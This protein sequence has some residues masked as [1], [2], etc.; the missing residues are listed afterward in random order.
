MK[1]IRYIL[2]IWAGKALIVLG[3]A[4]GKKGSSKP[5]EIAFKICPDVLKIL[6]GKVKKEIISVCGTN[7][8][9]TT[10]N[11]IDKILKEKGFKVVCNNIGA[12]MLPGIATAFIEKAG[13]FGG[14]N[15]DY[16][17]HQ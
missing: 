4:L 1:K 15:C 14:L 3:K 5:G 13:V 2:S 7:G 10:N 17:M 8:K 16:A 9:T 11:I 12:N 6:S